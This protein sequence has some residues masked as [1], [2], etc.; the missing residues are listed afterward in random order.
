MRPPSENLR[1][2]ES[3]F[4]SM[5]VGGRLVGL[6]K[7]T[8][9]SIFSRRS[10]VSRVFSSSSVVTQGS[11]GNSVVRRQR[12]GEESRGHRGHGTKVRGCQLST[13]SYQLSVISFQLSAFS[14]CEGAGSRKRNQG[15]SLRSE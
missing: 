13:F 9:Y 7:K 2:R 6:L 10:C 8:S 1:S 14:F 12:G 5:S 11:P 3:T 15:S 4:H